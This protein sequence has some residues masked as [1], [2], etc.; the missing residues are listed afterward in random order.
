MR[1]VAWFQI[2]IGAAV[3]GTRWEDVDLA[4]RFHASVSGTAGDPRPG[5][6]VQLGVSFPF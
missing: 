6:R 2:V 4:E 5:I 3:A 1:L